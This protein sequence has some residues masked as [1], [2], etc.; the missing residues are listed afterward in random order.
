MEQKLNAFITTTWGLGLPTNLFVEKTADFKL[1]TA[2][3]WLRD[4]ADVIFFPGGSDICPSIYLED[5][6]YSKVNAPNRDIRE[7]LFHRIAKR[8][9]LPMVGICR[10]HQLINALRGG[11]L[12]QDLTHEYPG[13]DHPAWHELENVKKG[14]MMEMAFPYEMTNSIHHQAVVDPGD[15][16]IVTSEYMDVAESTEGEDVFS[17]QGHP[18]SMYGN[19]HMFFDVVH[20]WIT[21]RR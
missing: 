2:V 14:S 21:S 6:T 10:G 1:S 20:N 12:T 16:L 5:N 7:I 15:G 17:V 9:G 8:K 18:E 11:H 4:W 13:I 19:N 3:A